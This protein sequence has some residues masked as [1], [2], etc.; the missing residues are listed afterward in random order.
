MCGRFA[1][2]LSY[3]EFSRAI[4]TMLP[5]APRRQDANAD[6]YHPS[7]NVAPG[8][9]FPVVR[10]E[11]DSI[12]V[13]TMRWGV[14]LEQLAPA[15]RSDVM[16]GHRVIN[17]RSDTLMNTRSV[18]HK[19]LVSQRCI[20]F[21]QGFYEWQKIPILGEKGNVRR[22]PHFVGMYEQ[23]EGRTDSAGKKKQLMPMAGLWTELPN[24]D[25]HLFT[26]VTTQ[27]N[28]QLDFLHDRMPLILSSTNAIAQWLGG[29]K[30]EATS[31]EV[32]A[33]LLKPFDGQLDCYAVAPEVGRVGVSHKNLILPVENRKDG[34]LA[35]FQAAKAKKAS[36]CKDS[37]TSLS[38]ASSG[39]NSEKSGNP[40]PAIKQEDARSFQ[41]EPNAGIKEEDETNLAKYH[42][43]PKSQAAPVP[44]HKLTGSASQDNSRSQHNHPQSPS[45]SPKRRKKL[46]HHKAKGTPSLDSFWKH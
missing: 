3:E 33:P 22:V 26:I 20:I 31:V 27:S 12:F 19:M 11:K 16:D 43:G 23:G 9:R 17:S 24:N 38:H 30:Q 37:D 5:P 4:D 36:A 34:I 13:E 2:G 25:E 42:G 40:N 8:T 46:E 45:R 35:M 6:E 7:Y 39:P 15:S 21:C 44:S 14:P 29:V 41:D 32:L 18:W 10:T 1:N 28:K